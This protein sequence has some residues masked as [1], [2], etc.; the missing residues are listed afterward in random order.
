M[1]PLRLSDAELDAILHAARPLPVEARDMFLRA[2][3]HR[4]QQECGE[5]GP[6]SVSRACREMQKQFFDPPEFESR[7]AVPRWS[8]HEPKFERVSKQAKQA[9]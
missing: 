5:I 6:G 8:R 9:V 3:A 4:L 2:V 7:G 1:P